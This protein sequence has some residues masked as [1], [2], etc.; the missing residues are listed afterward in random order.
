LLQEGATSGPSTTAKPTTLKPI[1]MATTTTTMK[2]PAPPQAPPQAA[3]PSRPL[4]SFCSGDDWTDPSNNVVFD[5]YVDANGIKTQSYKVQQD[6]NGR[7]IC[8]K[9]GNIELID[10]G[11]GFCQNKTVPDNCVSPGYSDGNTLYSC[12][13]NSTSHIYYNRYLPVN[14]KCPNNDMF[15]DE[16]SGYCL[17]AYVDVRPHINVLVPKDRNIIK[18]ML[19]IT[20]L[21]VT[22][23]V[24][25][26]VVIMMPQIH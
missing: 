1:A 2:P 25:T 10:S 18:D 15:V 16:R 11:N 24:N 17:S 8:P 23:R 13:S 19:K 3:A 14:G 4:P 26:L 5:C 22:V 6:S 9:Q 7:N 20:I 21:I 12:A